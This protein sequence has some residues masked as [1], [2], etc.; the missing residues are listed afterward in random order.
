MEGNLSVTNTKIDSKHSGLEGKFLS[1]YS[2]FFI[3]V[4]Q[5]KKKYSY[6]T[7][8]LPKEDENK[9]LIKILEYGSQK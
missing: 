6:Y 4:P 5:T 9:I 8:K 7:F 2:S 3:S 1:K